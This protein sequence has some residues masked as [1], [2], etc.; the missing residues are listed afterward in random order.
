[1][2]TTDNK[3][4]I[5]FIGQGFIG[6]AYSNN[7]ESR[8]YKVVRYDITEKWRGNKDAIKTCDLVFVAVPTPTTPKG[9]DDS[10]LIDAIGITGDQPIVIKS[11]VLPSTP[12]KIQTMHPGKVIMHSPEFLTEQTA[13]HDADNPLRNIIG[14]V[15]GFD[16]IRAN[17]AAQLALSVLPKAPYELV[18]TAETASLI[19][20]GGN[21]FLY[22]KVMLMNALYDIAASVGADWNTVTNAITND[23]RIGNTHMTVSH[24]GGRGAGGN[25]FVKDFAAF[26]EMYNDLCKDFPHAAD[27]VN[28]MKGMEKFNLDLLK[29]TNKSQQIVRGVYGEQF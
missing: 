27:A 15:T 19:K 26:R 21:C 14:Y 20:Y 28:Y 17:A 24:L 29:E 4:L 9:F 12:R 22:S 11:T 6:S 25:C 8:G 7:F 2:Q 13:Q 5:G 1:M 3:P 16:D 18:T 10:I 23:P